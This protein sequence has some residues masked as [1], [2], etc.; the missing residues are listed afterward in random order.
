MGCEELY[1]KLKQAKCWLCIKEIF[2]NKRKSLTSEVVEQLFS[3]D[4][5]LELWPTGG[6]LLSKDWARVEGEKSN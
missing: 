2:I 5:F 4:T 6:G 1:K 3:T